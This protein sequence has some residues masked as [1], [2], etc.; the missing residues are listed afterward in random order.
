MIIIM[1][2]SGVMVVM[3][4]YYVKLQLVSHYSPSYRAIDEMH[5]V[6]FDLNGS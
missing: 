6:E 3:A 2:S 1:I 5:G 4:M